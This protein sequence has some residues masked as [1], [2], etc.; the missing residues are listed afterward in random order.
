MGNTY[1]SAVAEVSQVPDPPTGEALDKLGH[2]LPASVVS[3]GARAQVL[4]LE[5][6]YPMLSTTIREA[7]KEAEW[8]VRKGLEYA[9]VEGRITS[10]QVHEHTDGQM[11]IV[12][13]GLMSLSEAAAFLE[14]SVERVPVLVRP[15]GWVEEEPVFLSEAVRRKLLGPSR[16]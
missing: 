2:V 14:V 12:R 15:V 9:G 3:H 1:W 11:H 5:W 8:A 4:R 13:V 16:G 10:V 6:S 7:V